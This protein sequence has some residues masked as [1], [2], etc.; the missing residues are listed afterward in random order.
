MPL[1]RLI[2]SSRNLISGS[3]TQILDEIDELIAKAGRRNQEHRVTGALLFNRHRFAQVIEGPRGGVETIFDRIKA[4]KL[5]DD[6]VVLQAEPTP[7][8]AFNGWGVAFVGA[9]TSLETIR[10]TVAL[11]QH[12]DADDEEGNGILSFLMVLARRDIDADMDAVLV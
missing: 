12:L 6:I 11:Q 1:F 8:R 10:R 9:Q 4:D 5:H 2:Y 7:N 3:N